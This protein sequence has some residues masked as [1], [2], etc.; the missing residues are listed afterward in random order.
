MLDLALGLMLLISALVSLHSKD[1]MKSG[2]FFLI[3]GFLSGL[4]WVRLEAFD[5]A[6][7]E[8]ILGSA[9]TGL[10]IFKLV[11][12]SRER[13]LKA[14]TF[15]KAWAVLV[16]L[17]FFLFMLSYL[18]TIEKQDRVGSLVYENLYKSGVESAVNAVLLNFRGYDTLLEVGVITLAIFGL[19]A[20]GLKREA[21][22]WDNPLL[23]SFSRLLLPFI[24]FFSLYIT[25][26]G[27]FSVGGAFQ[28]GALLAGGLVF[29]A[30]AKQN[31][32]IKESLILLFMVTGLGVFSLVGLIYALLGYGFLTYPLELSTFSLIIIELSIW[33]S[34]AFL[35]YTAYRGRL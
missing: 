18:P 14:F 23:K 20:L 33:I 24:A 15:T 29:F 4:I 30:L 7:V 9:I 10:L 32:P 11:K 8:I 13:G 28:G 19:L 5:V 26:L 1:L 27:T 35:L 17:L 6:L 16:S 31:L 22:H 2:V 25:Y 34:T 3:F 21:H 12:G